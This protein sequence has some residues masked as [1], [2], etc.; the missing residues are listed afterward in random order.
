MLTFDSKSD[1]IF[2]SLKDA[3][4]KEKEALDL[5]RMTQYNGIFDNANRIDILK[6]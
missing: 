6:K 5:Y 1:K 4:G 2:K 3:E